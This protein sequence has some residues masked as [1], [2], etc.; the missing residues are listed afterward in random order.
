MLICC[1]HN[2]YDL[3]LC[4]QV[5]EMRLLKQLATV[6]RQASAAGGFFDAWMK[7]QSDLVQGASQAFAGAWQP[8]S[9]RCGVVW[10]VVCR[11]CVRCAALMDVYSNLVHRA[12]RAIAGGWCC[13][14]MLCDVVW[15]HRC[16]IVFE[17]PGVTP[18]CFVLHSCDV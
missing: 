8:G 5:R 12:S 2:S 7:Q 15:R 1:K 6:M 16:G 9:I 17:R 18:S 4:L 10:C 14:S 13:D 3:A 11:L